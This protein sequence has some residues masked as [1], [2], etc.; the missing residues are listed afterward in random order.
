M[1]NIHLR[2]KPTPWIASDWGRGTGERAPP[3][4]SARLRALNLPGAGILPAP[5]AL[6]ALATEAIAEA[7][8]RATAK[9]RPW[10]ADPKCRSA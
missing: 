10:Y 6:P 4:L 9:R 1:R 7:P 3:V 5:Y 8:P 2:L